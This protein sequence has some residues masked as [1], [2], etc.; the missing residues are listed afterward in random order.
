M[1]RVEREVEGREEWEARVV[2]VER[3][4]AARAVA[5]DSWRQE[6]DAARAELGAVKKEQAGINARHV[7]AET[8]R[9]HL[10]VGGVGVDRG[11]GSRQG[12]IL[13]PATAHRPCVGF[14]LSVCA[15]CTVAALALRASR[16]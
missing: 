15:P 8:M 5:A 1:E 10:E 12:D 6:S 16:C 7:D 14:D 9:G 13:M 11:G 4:A 2:R 3:D